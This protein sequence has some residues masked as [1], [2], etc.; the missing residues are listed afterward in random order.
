TGTLT[1]EGLDLWGAVPTTT[2]TGM[3]SNYETIY[4]SLATSP[5]FLPAVRHVNHLPNG[6]LL[7]GMAACHSLTRIDDDLIGDPL[8]LKMFEWTGWELEEPGVADNEKYDM[9]TPTIV[10]PGTA[11]VNDNVPSTKSRNSVGTDYEVG[12]VRQFPFSSSLQRMS[13]ITKRPGEREFEL[14]CKGSPEM[15]VSL[16]TPESVPENFT[17]TLERYT[18]HGYRVIAM[19]SRTLQQNYAKAQRVVREEVETGLTFLGLIVLE[20]RLKPETT[21]AISVHKNAG[22]R[23]IMVTGDNMLTA[24]SVARECRMI[25]QQEKVIVITTEADKTGTEAKDSERQTLFYSYATKAGAADSEGT[26][27]PVSVGSG[28]GSIMEQTLINVEPPANRYV[29]AITGNAFSVAKNFYPEILPR[30]LVRGAVFARM[31]PDQK[32]QLVEHLQALGYFV[33]MCGDGANDCGALKAAHAGISLSEAESSVASPF[34]S[35]EAN[36]TCVPNLIREG[37]AALVTSFGIFKYM[38]IYSLT[39]FISVIVL[40]TIGSNLADKQFLYIDLF[41]ISVFAFT[42]GHTEPCPGPL[43]KQPPSANLV[44]VPPIVS[45]IAHMITILGTQ[46]LSFKYVQQQPWFTPYIVK[47]DEYASYE[48][49]AVFSVSAFQYIIMAVVFSQGSPYRKGFWTNKYLMLALVGLTTLTGYIVLYPDSWVIGQLELQLPP[50]ME[51]RLT[52][53]GFIVCNFV[54]AVLIEQGIVNFLL[55]KRRSNK[56]PAA[57][58]GYLQIDQELSSRED[59]PP[60]SSTPNG[61]VKGSSTDFSKR[62]LILSADTKS[63]TLERPTLTKV[64]ANEEDGVTRRGTRRHSSSV[65][66]PI[67]MADYVGLQPQFLPASNNQHP[68]SLSVDNSDSIAAHINNTLNN[69]NLNNKGSHSDCHIPPPQYQS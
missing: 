8:D 60:V 62:K 61:S 18:Q 69:A 25:E 66:I 23:T 59:W 30:I 10:R 53:I 51:F 21:A 52:L 11:E 35:K 56:P 27:S 38:A 44:S 14:Y 39:Q 26:Q 9:V 47:E 2:G 13:V 28:C 20:N 58:H 33:A 54:I 50:S 1:E 15:I 41:L 22:I 48:N 19:A 7:V 42:F 32:Q 68:Y 46:L 63:R 17:A 43:V 49:Y 36:I 55:S 5:G 12:V 57:K 3:G 34:T 64:N 4:P 16:S 29:F 45:I 6:P 40:Y 67:P 31:N 24:I 65:S 37:R